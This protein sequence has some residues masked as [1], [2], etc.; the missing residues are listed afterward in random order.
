ML[1]IAKNFATIFFAIR[2]CTYEVQFSPNFA[3]TKCNF[4]QFLHPRGAKPNLLYLLPYA[5]CLFPL[6]NFLPTFP[7][8]SLLFGIY[9]KQY[10]K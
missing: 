1:F 8:F 5:L 7:L 10:L 6:K 2:F 9:L 3:P 4:N